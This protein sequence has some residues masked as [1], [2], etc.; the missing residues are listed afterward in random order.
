M[1]SQ[2]SGCHGFI[3][4][5]CYTFFHVPSFIFNCMMWVFSLLKAIGLSIISCIHYIWTVGKV[6]LAII[7]HLLI[8]I[9][10]FQAVDETWKWGQGQWT[11]GRWNLRNK[12]LMRI[13]NSCLGHLCVAE[14]GALTLTFDMECLENVQSDLWLESAML[15]VCLFFCTCWKKCSHFADITKFLSYF[16]AV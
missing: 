14:K 5:N 4:L 9:D 1:L 13:W 15:S 8:F 6:S 7:P 16:H 2:V 10:F 3:C 12:R 11:F